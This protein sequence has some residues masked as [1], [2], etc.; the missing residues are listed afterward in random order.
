VTRVERE[1]LPASGERGTR[2]A[3]WP[4]PV[5]VLVL[6]SP[7]F[8]ATSLVAPLSVAYQHAFGL[9]PEAIGLLGA[10]T[11][12]LGVGLLLFGGWAAGR[13]GRVATMSVFD[14]LGFVLP[15]AWL[16]LARSPTE[17][18]AATL[19]GAAGQA[20]NVAYGALLMADLTPEQRPRVLAWEHLLLALTSAA[21]PLAASLL[22]GAWGL[23]PAARV[24]YAI[25]AVGVGAMVLVR[26]ALLRRR[27]GWTPPP[28]L[29]LGEAL[30][31]LHGT[32]A[33]PVLVAGALLAAGGALGLL[34][35]VRI[36]E[37]LR[38]DASWLG[39]FATVMT[40]GDLMATAALTRVRA[41]ARALALAGLLLAA[42][43]VAL[44]ALASGLLLVLGS[45]LVVG[46]AGPLAGLGTGAW[47]H[48]AVPESL[49]DH[50]STAQLAARTAGTFAGSALAGVL[51]T[52]DP[53][54]PWWAAAGAFLLAALIL[55]PR[56]F[57]PRT[58]E[59]A[60]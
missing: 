10:A 43:G 46:I 30:R 11:S 23:V 17:V 26:V 42:L 50:A 15:F 29:A 8:A 7:L 27:G 41:H 21:L 54:W 6:T 35:Q 34:A 51:Y 40:A 36:T 2:S 57:L 58:V 24:L 20:A 13:W 53:A 48:D 38:L 19:L 16:A 9:G 59:A 1:P 18:A 45:A 37:A 55:V 60:V 12:A 47:L 28:R 32:G 14:G 33:T 3:D 22:V 31:D 25:A 44:F 39:P 49:R 5:R 52:L 4:R 56:R